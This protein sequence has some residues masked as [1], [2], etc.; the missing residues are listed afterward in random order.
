MKKLLITG[1]AGFVAG[2]FTEFL[3]E[4]KL[5]IVRD[6]LD[7]RD[8]VEAYHKMPK[9]SLAQTLK[10]MITYQEKCCGK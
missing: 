8:V 4:N 10:D 6:F 5:R 1:A 7:V 9:H 3:K 2:Y